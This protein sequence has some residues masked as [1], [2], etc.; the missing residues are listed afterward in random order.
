V[1]IAGFIDSDLSSRF[2]P[3]VFISPE[4]AASIDERWTEFK[5]LSVES[6]ARSFQ[7]DA[8][9]NIA[10]SEWILILGAI[11]TSICL[12]VNSLFLSVES[13]RREIA[14][15]RTL[16]MTKAAVV[17]SLFAQ[18]LAISSGGFVAGVI[19]S[20]VSL[21][22]YVFFDP[23]TFPMGAVVDFRSIF[24]VFMV[25]PLV[26]AVSVL[27]AM[28]SALRVKPLEITS[29]RVARRRSIGMVIAFAVGFGVFVAIEVWGSSLTKPFI[30][31][32]EW[33][34]AIVSILPAGVSS[35]DIEKL[36]S[37]KS[38]RQIS[39]LQPLQVNIL[40]LEELKISGK[41][42]NDRGNRKKQY[43]NALLL[44]SS[45]L[46]DFKFVEGVRSDAVKK[47]Q[48]GDACIITKMMANAR[49]LKLGDKIELDCTRSH[50]MS[51]EIVGIIDLNWHMVTSRALLR[52]LNR[53]SSSTDGPVFVSFDT[54][55]AC[56][57]R[58][59]EYVKMTHL[60]LDYDE[61]FL[62][63]HGV[64]EAGRKVEQ[65]IVS[66]L[67]GAYLEETG[68]TVRGN[69]VRLHSRDEVADGTLS[70]SANLVGAMA[71]IPFIFVVIISLGFIAMLVSSAE[72]RK[73]EFAVLRAVGAT[74]LMLA[75]ILIKEAL[76]VSLFAILIAS[77]C[78]SLMGWLCT[79]VTRASMVNWGLPSS[80]VFPFMVIAKGAF[81]AVAFALLVS[82]PSSIMIIEKKFS[83]T[84]AD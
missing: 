52:G 59:Q 15:L 55:A 26:A 76:T 66:A 38:V 70:H 14:I 47:M 37:I 22:I 39:E 54:L 1:K 42:R 17:K 20:V 51:L 12:I 50:K 34:S 16:G 63:E 67:D 23:E 8:Q 11:L 4:V 25:T 5:P 74:K 75:G 40:P 53:M 2:Y 73:Y 9:S 65:E 72:S 33:P 82:I 6:L 56:D 29:R 32:K 13:R 44:A 41:H 10:R 69:T 35:F 30:P 28:A 45:H 31:S 83:K 79:W 68:G 81:F 62:L 48:Q 18:A 71:R 3:N 46:P 77:V 84:A 27:F 57:Y 78:G 58:P 36:S 43:R 24:Y 7:S 49:K 21:L 19:V 61:D 80:F 60:W 64:F